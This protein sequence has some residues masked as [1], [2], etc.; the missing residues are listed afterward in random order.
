MSFSLKKNNYK[1]TYFI[2]DEASMVSNTSGENVVFG[3][4]RLLDD[5]ISY[6]YGGENCH[7]I[8]LGDIAQLPPVGYT[9]S[10]ALSPEYLHGYGLTVYCYSLTEVAPPATRFRYLKKRYGSAENNFFGKS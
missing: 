1:D 4:G 7:L 6:V 5:L 2:V 8:F 9:D 10:P 3:T